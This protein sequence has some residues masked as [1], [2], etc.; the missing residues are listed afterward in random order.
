MT[1]WFVLVE[2]NT[3][4]SGQVF[5]A[6][7]RA[8]GLRPIVLTAAPGRYP[9][10]DTDS[11]DRLVVDTGD[12]A[13]VLAA[14]RSLSRVVGITSSSE[15]FIATAA[16]VAADL[17]LPGPDPVAVRSCRDKAWQ[18]ATLAGAGIAVPGFRVVTTD[19]VDG[20]LAARELG[21]PVVVK[22]ATGSGSLGVRLCADEDEV[23]RAV[24]VLLAMTT[25]ERGAPREPVVLVERFARG[26][27]FSVETVGDTVAGITG[28][29]LGAQPFFVETGHDF[30][31]RVRDTERD[32]L[33]E[34]TLAALSALGVGWGAAHTELRLTPTGPVLIEVNP[35][36]AGGMIP[37]VVAAATGLDLVDACV[38]RACGEPP[39]TAVGGP[40]AAAIRFVLARGPGVVSAVSGLREAAA[41]PGVAAARVTT[42][43]G[44]RLGE[45]TGSFQDRVGHVITTAATASTAAARA[46]AALAVVGVAVSRAARADA[47]R[48]PR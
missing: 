29:H 13:A 46:E 9:Y 45:P 35:R 10:L 20:V 5:C 34:T 28:K 4:G 8:R 22:P 15:Y 43:V 7:A 26:R 6:R 33:V 36:L 3:T 16:E 39:P 41:L 23:A 38:A 25:D 42:A 44:A 2:S 24:G 27:E 1:A 40:G 31:A 17:G 11:V 47:V 14:C 21:F 18:R 30:P 48:L 32:E 19:A 37:A 12:A